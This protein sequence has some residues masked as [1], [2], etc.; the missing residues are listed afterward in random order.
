[1]RQRTQR[2]Y[3]ECTLGDWCKRPVSEI[4][5]ESGDCWGDGQSLSHELIEQGYDAMPFTSGLWEYLM[6]FNNE[7][8][9][10]VESVWYKISNPIEKRVVF[11]NKEK[12]LE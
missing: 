11:T 6:H 9:K 12:V 1:M 2:F 3:Y 4:V 7:S 5:E 10:R 8:K